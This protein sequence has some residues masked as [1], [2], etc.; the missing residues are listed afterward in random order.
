MDIIR[1]GDLVVCDYNYH[2]S[3][4]KILKIYE[5]RA[6]REYEE[7]GPVITGLGDANSKLDITVQ[8]LAHDLRDGDNFDDVG[9]LVMVDETKIVTANEVY[10]VITEED[11]N[12]IKNEWERLMRTKLDFFYQNV[13]RPPLS[14]RKIL[15]SL[16]F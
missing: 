5:L 12:S 4:A 8:I 15:N 14:G 6:K 10:R 1:V 9:E 2:I 13:N 7:Y 11:I 16:K 3:Y